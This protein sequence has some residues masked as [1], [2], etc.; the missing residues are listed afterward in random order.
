MHSRRLPAVRAAVEGAVVRKV[1]LMR[2]QLMSP[3]TVLLS[4]VMHPIG[5]FVT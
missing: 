2:T 1:P 3:L 4:M 5:L